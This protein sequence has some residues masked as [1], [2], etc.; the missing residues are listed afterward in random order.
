MREIVL[1][2]E[3]TGLDA[4]AG[5]RVVEIGCIELVNTVATGRTF[6][7]YFNPEMIMP[8]GAQD[9]HRLSDEFLSH[10]ALSPEKAA[11]F[12]AFIAVARLGIRSPQVDLGCPTCDHR[13]P[14]LP[15]LTHHAVRP[16]S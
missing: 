14:G 4:L 11:A 15:Q 9:I 5:H 16:A 12:L 3:T 10:K 13:S 2:T 6:H 1:D 8:T 7:A